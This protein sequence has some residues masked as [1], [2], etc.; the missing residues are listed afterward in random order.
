VPLRQDGHF[1]DELAPKAKCRKSCF[2]LYSLP[3]LFRD[4]SFPV[5]VAV[6]LCLACT[7]GLERSLPVHPDTVNNHSG[8]LLHP[9]CWQGN[10][11]I[12]PSL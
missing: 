7:C 6:T 5:Q 12:M 8:L 4:I 10:T 11:Y 3:F 9:L 1:A 2:A